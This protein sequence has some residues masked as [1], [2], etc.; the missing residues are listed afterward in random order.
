[1]ACITNA[2]YTQ[3][4]IMKLTFFY[5]NTTFSEHLTDLEVYLIAKIHKAWDK[6]QA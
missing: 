3:R 2:T 5:K 1:M 4:K 6:N